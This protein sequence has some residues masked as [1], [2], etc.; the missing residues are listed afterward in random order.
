M[1]EANIFPKQGQ[2]NK[3]GCRLFAL[4][5]LPLARPT[6]LTRW[7]PPSEPKHLGSDRALSQR[8]Q[9]QNERQA[10]GVT[11]FNEPNKTS[12]TRQ[13]PLRWPGGVP[14]LW[15]AVRGGLQEPASGPPS[16][17]WRPRSLAARGRSRARPLHPP[18]EFPLTTTLLAPPPHP[19]LRE[20][21][22][23]A[24]ASTARLTKGQ[25]HPGRPP[26]PLAPMR[27]P[28]AGGVLGLRQA[29]LNPI[30]QLRLP[31]LWKAQRPGAAASAWEPGAMGHILA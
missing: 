2:E 10:G 26:P 28:E 1:Q 8:H 20:S 23:E 21:P 16:G 18:R 6:G 25:G 31:F 29:T 3:A 9:N 17:P 13:E 15:H 27:P 19:G 24:K 4:L 30:W 12:Q 11:G 7:L 22:P 14:R 5:F